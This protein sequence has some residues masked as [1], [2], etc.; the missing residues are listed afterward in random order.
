[1]IAER[2]LLERLLGQ[3][4]MGAV[5]AG[6]HVVTG[7]RVAIKLLREDPVRNRAQALRMAREAR[8]VGRIQH[9][10]VVAVH[11]AGFAGGR[12]FIAMELLDGESLEQRIERT[13]PMSEAEAVHTLQQIALGVAAAHANGIIH[14][15]LKPA[16]IL[17]CRA[18][19]STRE[20]V[21]VV[22]F[23]ISKLRDDAEE[24][25]LV[26]SHGEQ[27]GTPMFMSPEQVRGDVLDER[28]DVYALS[29]IVYY[30]LTQRFPFHARSR[31]E[32]FAKI[33]T[34]PPEPLAA[35]RAG[36]SAAIAAVVLRGL[37][38]ERA[39]RYE[40]VAALAEALSRAS[41]QR[42][43]SRR[44]S[45]TSRVV[46]LLAAA[47]GITLALVPTRLMH[48]AQPHQEVSVTNVAEPSWSSSVPTVSPV[49]EEADT[50]GA[51]TQ[52]SAAVL[53][54]SVL[55]PARAPKP[56]PARPHARPN[57]RGPRYTAPI[58]H[59]DPA[60]L[61]RAETAH[62]EVKLMSW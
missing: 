49:R 61:I 23:G 54:P 25:V 40:S 16:N 7:R 62:D 56:A 50:P 32:L 21:K 34:A 45:I 30:T 5:F 20:L 39:G 11:D 26:T 51:A 8:A 38:R 33:L 29:V 1:V 9:P 24:D 59:D 4:G 18:D 14:R 19:G 10:N 2:Y 12:P 57:A 17:L 13:G 15:D 3:G 43:R 6:R 53:E 48:A 44:V 37:A 52:P 22:D 46:H 58:T 36:V 35:H 28:T 55:Q 42:P 47:S 27:L 31:A 41:A 60:D